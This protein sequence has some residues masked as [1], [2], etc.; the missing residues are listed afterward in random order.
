MVAAV[1]VAGFLPYTFRASQAF[2]PD[3]LMTASIIAT[4]ALLVAYD[5]TPRR[6]TL[7]WLIL[8]ASA[9]LFV[10][11]FAALYVAPPA[12]ALAWRR[13]RWRGVLGVAAWLPLVGVPAAL[14]YVHVLR[15][16]PGAL[17]DDR[18]FPG[19]LLRGWFWSGWSAM[20]AR[21]L[22]WPVALLALAGIA[23]APSRPRLV[24]GSVLA[25][26]VVSGLLFT[27]HISTHDYYSLP[28][29]PVAALG[30]GA[31]VDALAR[32]L[33][34]RAR[35]AAAAVG[36]GAAALLAAAATQTVFPLGPRPAV[37]ARAA[38]EA[39]IGRDVAHSAKVL[40]LDDSYGYSLD[41]DG[42]LL[43]ANL[44]LSIDLQVLDLAG[45]SHP[46]PVATLD[47]S[48]AEYF[49][50]TLQSEL[51][52]QPALE[53]AL[54]A[55]HP[56]LDRDGDAQRWNFLVFDLRRRKI[57]VS[58]AAISL[59]ATPD[60]RAFSLAQLRI[61]AAPDVAWRSQVSAP[62]VLRVEP[63]SGRGAATLTLRPASQSRPVDRA[64]T[65][66][67]S[68]DGMV[69]AS[70]DVRV[71]TV[72]GGDTAAPF[73]FVDA[74]ANPIPHLGAQPFVV[75]GWALDDFDLRRV[76]GEAIDRGGR[77]VALGDAA[78]G[79]RRADVAAAY[80]DGI[81]NFRNAWLLVVRPD[82]LRRLQFPVDLRIYAADGAGRQ[83]IIGHRTI[84]A[85]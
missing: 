69:P 81:D 16:A 73:G 63:E 24:L 84:S 85:P 27:H 33:T 7:V 9:A 52:A 48:G 32:A 43:A 41:Y 22:T 46:D 21:V 80:P 77:Q 19:L 4:L 72:A 44:P 49:V 17:M 45:R 1:A 38:R 68:S 65:V 79:G 5:E 26:Y 78:R 82:A 50:A 29:V 11:P 57:D 56:L 13:A 3:A 66:T 36:L 70:V 59:F 53:H 42:R 55:N 30:A 71:K 51:D 25:G 12:L 58:P 35:A 14:W 10:K 2:Q 76:W 47:S 6:R 54:E 75:Q 34:G 60:A 23:A 83:T 40:S 39:R 8:V 64:A 18:F 67:L 31:A 37:A 28:F 20:I 61:E 15:V 62:D 74:P